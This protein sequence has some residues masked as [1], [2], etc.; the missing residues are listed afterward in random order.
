M[1][2]TLDRPLTSTRTANAARKVTLRH[3]AQAMN[4]SISTISMALSGDPEIGP[5]TRRRVREIAQQL[6]YVPRKRRVHRD[7]PLT[8]KTIRVAL[9]TVGYEESPI[10]VRELLQAVVSTGHL[11]QCRVELAG[12]PNGPAEQ[13]ISRIQQIKGE[14]G[15]DVVDGF[16]LEGYITAELAS[17]LVKAGIPFVALG[18][19]KGDPLSQPE[20]FQVV[21][22]VH[23]M[24]YRATHEMILR[25][26][27]RPAITL[28]P[29]I[30]NL[31][32]YHWLHG[33]RHA[34][35]DAGLT[36]DPNFIKIL[37]PNDR[38]WLPS[39]SDCVQLMKADAWIFANTNLMRNVIH[40]AQLRGYDIPPARRVIGTS[41][42]AIMVA[43]YSDETHVSLDQGKLGRTGMELLL[44]SL[45]QRITPPVVVTVPYDFHPGRAVT[46]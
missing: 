35:I 42:G 1:S 20:G 39:E 34:M 23:G 4:L 45:E 31:W 21:A 16:L 24:A 5:E 43:A 8:E 36:P 22:D 40:W 17:G 46:A 10:Y 12:V 25:G 3:I 2:A 38:S 6:N 41:R 28:A 29:V 18:Q 14:S 9:V 37:P 11:R 30:D 19:L 27:R 26:A 7:T 32:S 33:Y 44:A 13:Q 15:S